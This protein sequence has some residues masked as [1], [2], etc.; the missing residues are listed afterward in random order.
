MSAGVVPE[1]HGITMTR[2]ATHTHTET[3]SMN[4]H[5]ENSHPLCAAIEKCARGHSYWLERAYLNSKENFWMIVGQG[6]L[7]LLLQGYKRLFS[8]KSCLGSLFHTRLFES[9]PTR[10]KEE[11]D[12]VLKKICN[13]VQNCMQPGFFRLVLLNFTCIKL[14]ICFHPR[15]P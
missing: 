13:W 12:K 3:G 1:K 7:S 2:D 14:C 10:V 5:F 4:M 9:L 6:N 11:Q 15:E 8:K